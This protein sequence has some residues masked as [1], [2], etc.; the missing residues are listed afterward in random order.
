MYICTYVYHKRT[1]MQIRNPVDFLGFIASTQLHNIRGKQ[2]G[3]FY[4]TKLNNENG[5]YID[6]IR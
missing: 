5:N 6:I 2:Q 1:N 3:A 4:L